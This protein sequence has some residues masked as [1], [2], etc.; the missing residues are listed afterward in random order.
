MASRPVTEI[1]PEERSWGVI[2]KG[3]LKY[4]QISIPDGP[5]TKI[6][7]RDKLGGGD[8]GVTYETHDGKALKIVHLDRN[9]IKT[10]EFVNESIAQQNIGSIQNGRTTREVSHGSTAG[11][12]S[13]VGNTIAP[14]VYLYHPLQETPQTQL[15]KY[16]YLLMDKITPI[17]KTE[18]AE[19]VYSTDIMGVRQLIECIAI[20]IYN[21]YIHNDLHIG[22]IAKN[23]NQNAFVL[24][25]FGF[26]QNIGDFLKAPS[27]AP[28]VSAGAHLQ[29]V[30]DND[31]KRIL[32]NQILI[33]QLYALIEHCNSNNY[34]IDCIDAPLC[35]KKVPKCKRINNTKT[36]TLVSPNEVRL[37]SLII[38]NIAHQ[39]AS[40]I[41]GVIYNLRSN[42]PTIIMGQEWNWY[43]W[44]HARSNRIDYPPEEAINRRESQ[45]VDDHDDGRRATKRRRPMHE[46]GGKTRNIT[47]LSI[48][49]IKPRRSRNKRSQKSSK[50]RSQKAGGRRRSFKSHRRTSPKFNKNN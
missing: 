28:G 50:K 10:R 32:F 24:I 30:A 40:A 25:D 14:S 26:T 13:I 42:K 47:K 33:A 39:C 23:L 19:T 16:G 11:E 49:N 6:I 44:V 31:R 29:P 3:G 18:L 34:D 37:D 20:S 43:D 46:G 2:Y 15:P 21:G 17:D 12:P 5:G 1:N 36:C 38:S 27:V 41:I 7:L 35:T 8:N 22:N 4:K 48:K 45:M 9:S